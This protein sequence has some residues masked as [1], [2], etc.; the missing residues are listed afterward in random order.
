VCR[1][2]FD[3]CMCSSYCSGSHLLEVSML[4]QGMQV[5]CRP[6]WLPCTPT[7]WHHA[8]PLNTLSS[9][10]GAGLRPIVY[11]K[12]YSLEAASTSNPPGCD[13]GLL[14]N[15]LLLTGAPSFTYAG[16]RQPLMD[17][18]W[19]TGGGGT[20]AYFTAERCC[21]HQ[22]AWHTPEMQAPATKRTIRLTKVGL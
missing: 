3:I 5:S 2:W 20:C 9:T 15:C 16:R 19:A 10:A 4:P 21:P 13:A 12:L 11:R 1:R 8:Q 14:G 7:I 22:M 18:P 6:C 17:R